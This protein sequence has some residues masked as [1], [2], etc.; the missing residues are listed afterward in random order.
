MAKSK[1]VSVSKAKLAETGEELEVA[2]AMTEVEGA[3]GDGRRAARSAGGKSRPVV[4]VAA[5][6]AGA[7]DLTSAADAAADAEHVSN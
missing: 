2:G 6:A 7:S 5:V 1:R 3:T 4:G